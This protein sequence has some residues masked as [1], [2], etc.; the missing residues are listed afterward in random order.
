MI[1]CRTETLGRE[2]QLD[3][4]GVVSVHKF[5]YK[6]L[7]GPEAHSLMEALNNL[8]R[9]QLLMY[10]NITSSWNCKYFHHKV[11]GEGIPS[12][13]LISACSHVTES[14]LL[15]RCCYYPPTPR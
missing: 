5:S 10:A 2:H 1:N 12:E 13:R 8:I 4:G 6:H 3:G 15:L 9:I 7:T 14:V 11:K